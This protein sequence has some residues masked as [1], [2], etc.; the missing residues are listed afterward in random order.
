MCNLFIF[1]YLLERRKMKNKKGNKLV[2]NTT[3]ID[4]ITNYLFLPLALETENPLTW[5]QLR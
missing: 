4:E 3:I 5:W 1:I 2:Q